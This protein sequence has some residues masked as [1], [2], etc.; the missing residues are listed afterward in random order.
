MTGIIESA[1]LQIVIHL[2]NQR[3][4]ALFDKLRVNEVYFLTPTRRMIAVSSYISME[5]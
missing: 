1:L 4:A 3:Q 5:K 2:S